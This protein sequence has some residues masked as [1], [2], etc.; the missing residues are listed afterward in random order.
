MTT[1]K[2][3]TRYDDKRHSGARLDAILSDLRTVPEAKTVMDLGA[4][5]GFFSYGLA[6]AGYDVTAVEPPNGKEFH[7]RVRPYRT[8]VKGPEDLPDQEFDVVLALNVLHHI[9][10]W[11]E[12]FKSI[13]SST[14]DRVYVEVPAPEEHHPKWCGAEEQRI[15]ITNLPVKIREAV[16]SF[17][18]VNQKYKRTLWRIDTT[19]RLPW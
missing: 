12:V 10:R 14:R 13:L 18:E 3:G 16:G 17:Y 5:M 6:N 15:L 2:W 1:M 4:N 8:L 19:P 7:H 9:P 11:R